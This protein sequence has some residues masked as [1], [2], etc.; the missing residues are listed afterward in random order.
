MQVTGNVSQSVIPKED[1]PTSSVQIVEIKMPAI[2]AGILINNFKL[3]S[4]I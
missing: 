4:Y 2:K 3:E 1:I